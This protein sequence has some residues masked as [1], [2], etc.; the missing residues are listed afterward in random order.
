MSYDLVTR[1]MKDFRT[2]LDRLQR[3]VRDPLE[4]MVGGNNTVFRTR[5][6]PVSSVPT[7]V[8]FTS[9][10]IDPSAYDLDTDTGT[11]V[12][13]SPP[14]S[15]PSMTYS[16]SNLT[17]TRVVETMFTGF[18]EMESR[19]PRRFKLIDGEG[20]EV[21]Y[22]SEETE[23]Y[24]VDQNGVD[25]PC[26]SDTFSTSAAER[27]LFLACARYSY[28]SGLIGDEADKAI[29][30]REDR[31]LT[32]DRRFVPENID[33]A[34]LKADGDV[35]RALRSAQAQFYTRGEH[36]G[37]ALKQPG[38]RDYFSDYEWQEDSRSQDYRQQESA[39]T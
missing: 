25:P 22:P 11:V 14:T 13:G 29:M 31:G 18:H 4:G 26:G 30:F 28:L 7:P 23:I 20:T 5:H 3:Q 32:V 27:N 16:W 1:G 24:V 33:K 2:R 39:S 12:F 10:S 6:R 17:D 15:Q 21:L 37:T 9:A 19:W 36:L 8:L 35:D 38:T 34:L